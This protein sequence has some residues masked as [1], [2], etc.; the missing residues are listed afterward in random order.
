MCGASRL[1]RSRAQSQLSRLHEV[2]R[3]ASAPEVRANRIGIDTAAYATG[4][5]TCLILPAPFAGRSAAMITA[6]C[7][8]QS[9]VAQKTSI[10]DALEFFGRTQRQGAVSSFLVG[11]KHPC[12]DQTD[13]WS[14]K[15]QFTSLK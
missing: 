5:L 14:L 7:R 4:R 10:A 1:G 8:G 12:L 3:G 11:Q 2:G 6:R 13:F 15:L 9:T